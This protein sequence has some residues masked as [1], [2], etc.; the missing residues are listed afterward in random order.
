[1]SRIGAER[2][3]DLLKF[4]LHEKHVDHCGG[5]CNVSVNGFPHDCCYLC[6]LT[7]EIGELY[8]KRAK[9]FLWDDNEVDQ[10]RTRY[11]CLWGDGS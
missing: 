6:N 10:E 9:D 8:E 2:A 7:Q 4:V 1:M 11:S 3:L 5:P